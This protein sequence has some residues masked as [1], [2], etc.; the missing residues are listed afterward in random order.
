MH[1]HK[2]TLDDTSK[3]LSYLLRH[4]PQAI[5]L[6]LDPEGWAD[7]DA[8]VAGAARH[9]R[10]LDRATIEA[11]VATNDKK[12]FALSDDG[13]RIRAVQGHSTPAVQRQYP[14][15]QPPDVLY[16][17]TAT[18]FLESIHAQGLKAG[19]RHHVH[20]SQDMSTAISVGKRY[21]KPV[22]LAIRA[23][24]MHE[25]GFRFFMAENGVWLTDAVPAEFLSL[26]DAPAG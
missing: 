5:G 2:K 15:R 8:L 12:R 17:G 9:G 25:R 23:R 7:I 11:V 24:H 10:Q 6:Q 1:T 22:V 4:E 16:H 14:E 19:T 13:R 20:L 21:G 18:R 3:Y 26:L